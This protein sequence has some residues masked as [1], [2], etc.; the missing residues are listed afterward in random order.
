MEA[1]VDGVASNG[2]SVDTT[3]E[4]KPA[5]PEMITVA[6]GEKNQVK[7]V[8]HHLGE[9]KLT[10]ASN[11]VSKQLVVKAKSVGSGTQVEISQ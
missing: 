9:S 5:D 2:S 8:V 3:A 4:W 6:P 11:G 10:V 7:I 1:R